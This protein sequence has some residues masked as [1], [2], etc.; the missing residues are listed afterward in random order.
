MSHKNN[1]LFRKYA[2]AVAAEVART[3]D[4][5]EDRFGILFRRIQKDVIKMWESLTHKEKFAFRKRMIR[6]TAALRK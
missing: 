3:N 1:K 5:P 2:G 6:D 4:V